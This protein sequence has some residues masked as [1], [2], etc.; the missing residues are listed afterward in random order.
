MGIDW[1]YLAAASLLYGMPLASGVAIFAGMIY[2]II[3]D[4]A[5]ESPR[6]RTSMK[7]LWPF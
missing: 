5:A 2:G 4:V 6:R 3:E 7:Q 1:Q